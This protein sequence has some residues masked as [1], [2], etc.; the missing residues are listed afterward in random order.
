[1][2]KPTPIEPIIKFLFE[3]L[4]FLNAITTAGK[5]TKKPKT[6]SPSIF[7]K[8][9]PEEN[10]VFSESTTP[11]SGSMPKS[12]ITRSESAVLFAKKPH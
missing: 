11:R 5:N 1:M 7:S 3:V 6:P 4:I 12:A 8:L 10:Q 2:T 9:F